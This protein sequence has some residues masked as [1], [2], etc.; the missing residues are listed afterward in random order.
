[1]LSLIESLK[2]LKKMPIVKYK[3]INSEQDL[4]FEFP[5]WLKADISGHKT[6][7]N[8][9]KKCRNKKEAHEN[10]KFLRKNFP[11]AEIIM[12]EQA[13]GIEMIIGLKQDK[14]FG[15]LLMIGFGG[16]HTEVVR[17]ISFRALPIDKKEIEKMIRELKMFPALV[18]R[19]K[20]ALDK[21]IDLAEKV[22]WLQV[23]EMD[24][25]PVMLN[26][27]EAVIVDARVEV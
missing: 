14:V 9:V 25:N 10:L 5:F 6:E 22:S 1:M 20:Y 21:F 4:S 7:A 23:K 27:N 26:E 8:A 17:D 12:Q 19:K 15:K 3:L 11:D 16:I 24:L 13:E 2:F 18:T